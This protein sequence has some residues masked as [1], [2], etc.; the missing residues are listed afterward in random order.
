MQV[1][2]F[3]EIEP[4][5]KAQVFYKA[6]EFNARIINLSSN[7]QIPSCEMDSYVLFY[8]LSG[9]VE[10]TVD[11]EKEKLDEQKCLITEPA[12]L[13][14]KTGNGVKILGLQIAKKY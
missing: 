13:S 4:E 3:K 8:V 5:K 10:V 1:F 14:M 2:D 11:G 6:D 12:T 9:E 7:G